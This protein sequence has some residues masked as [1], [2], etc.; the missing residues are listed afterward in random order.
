MKRPAFQVYPADWRKDV[1]LGHCR[2]LARGLW[3][4]ML[5]VMHECKP[6]GHLATNG[7]AMSDGDA[8]KACRFPLESYR[9]AV[10]NLE[11]NGV[12]SRT[13]EGV[14]FS[15]RMVRDERLRAMRAAAGKQGGNPVLLKQTGVASGPDLLNHP[16]PP[17][18]LHLQSSASAKIKDEEQ[19]IH[20]PGLNGSASAA[21]VLRGTRMALDAKPPEEWMQW[22]AKAYGIEPQRAVRLF[23]EFRDYWSDIP[24][25]KGLKLRWFGTFKNRLRDLNARGKL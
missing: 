17:L 22:A 21:K 16:V 10:R 20:P 4:E 18:H 9:N 15:R 8:A 11:A 1:E 14:I 5:C 19:H 7:V 24:G 3:W 13:P 6:Y 2:P 25:E 23:I 12:F